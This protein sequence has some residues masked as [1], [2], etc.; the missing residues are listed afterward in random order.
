MVMGVTN[1][2]A[3]VPADSGNAHVVQLEQNLNGFIAADAGVLR[4]FYRSTRAEIVA[5]SGLVNGQSV[6][7][8]ANTAGCNLEIMR[9]YLK[10]SVGKPGVRL[11]RSR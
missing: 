6:E 4:T 3:R 8:I 9:A 10:H 7:K 11:T 1:A 5:V 2:G